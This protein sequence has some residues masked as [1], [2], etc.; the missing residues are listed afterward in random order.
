MV[1]D[2]DSHA[3]NQMDMQKYG[4]FMAR[5]GWAQKNDILNTLSYNDFSDWL[6]K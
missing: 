5:R 2:S 1:I 3:V 4:V 6:S